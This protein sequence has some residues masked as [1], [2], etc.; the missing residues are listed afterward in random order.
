MVFIFSDE[1]LMDC[2]ISSV[3]THVISDLFVFLCMS[4]LWKYGKKYKN[5]C[6][7][8]LNNHDNNSV[9]ENKTNQTQINLAMPWS[10]KS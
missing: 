4:L 7:G 5:K 6:D 2:L 10:E 9:I 8:N 3:I 1:T